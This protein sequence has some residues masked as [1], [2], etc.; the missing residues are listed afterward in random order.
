MHKLKGFTLIE[1]L[2]VVAII[3]LLI[4]ILI[5]ATQLVKRQAKTAACQSNLHQ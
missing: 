2:T 3:V 5:P 4:A 1:L